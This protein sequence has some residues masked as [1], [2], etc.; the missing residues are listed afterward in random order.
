MKISRFIPLLYSGRN[1]QGRAC[2]CGGETSITNA[3]TPSS[4]LKQPRG[5]THQVKFLLAVYGL[6]VNFVHLD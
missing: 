3:D 6:V 5:Y 2:E 1:A 4:T